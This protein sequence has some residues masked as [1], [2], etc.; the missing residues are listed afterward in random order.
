MCEC[1]EENEAAEIENIQ[2]LPPEEVISLGEVL[3]QGDWMQK[4]NKLV[5]K[6]SKG[7][8]CH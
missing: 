3:K 6:W 2:E 5:K 4:G 1:L 8:H 7:S